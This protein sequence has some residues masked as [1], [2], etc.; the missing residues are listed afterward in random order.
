MNTQ[1]AEN[2]RPRAGERVDYSREPVALLKGSAARSG[3][4]AADSKER[5]SGSPGF[6]ARSRAGAADSKAGAAH[7]RERGTDS[8]EYA[9]D[10]KERAAGSRARATDSEERAADS[11]EFVT[12]SLESA[13]DPRVRGV[14]FAAAR[15]EAP[16]RGGHAPARP[17]AGNMQPDREGGPGGRAPRLVA[18]VSRAPALIKDGLSRIGLAR[19]SAAAPGRRTLGGGES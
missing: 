11:R 5:G 13:A 16:E 1:E 17:R 9:V 7:S 3:E 8:L 6:A 14:C 12:G 10:S 4:C 19:G 15:G 18:R 2:P